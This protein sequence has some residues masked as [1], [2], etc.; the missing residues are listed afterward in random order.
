MRATSSG[1]CPVSSRAPTSAPDERTATFAVLDR[2]H[3]A[4]AIVTVIGS[5][6]FL[7]ALM[8]MLVDERRETM[9]TL[10][11]IGF[12]RARL[13]R[14]VL[15]EGGLIAVAGALFGIAFALAAEPAF[16]RF[17]QWRYDTALVFLRITPAIVVPLGP[18]GAPRRAHRQRG[19]RL[20]DSPSAVPGAGGTVI[21]RAL[22][23][24][25]LRVR[26]EPGRTTLGVLGVTAIGALLFDMLLLSNGLLVSFRERLDRSG[27]DVRV[28]AGESPVLTGPPIED[29]SRA[30]AALRRLPAIAAVQRLTV[31]V[32]R[33]RRPSG[34]RADHGRRRGHAGARS[35]EHGLGGCARP[36][37]V[38]ARDRAQSRAVVAPRAGGWIRVDAAGALRRHR[39]AAADRRPGRRDRRFPERHGGR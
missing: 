39:R 6:A 15:I 27:F 34:A 9:A 5:G 18:D 36:W 37:R 1:A 20:D 7:L 19:G 32:R 22:R 26:R 13:L 33:S 21:G 30:I 10:R 29:A 23:L 25:W 12:T 2:F 28:M 14:Q 35:V 16:N 11:L 24:A 38:D 17:F 3:L 31:G 8:V 4:I